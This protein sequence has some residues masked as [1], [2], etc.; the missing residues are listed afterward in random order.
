MDRS[1][2]IRGGI[3]G[4]RRIDGGFFFFLCALGWIVGVA[5]DG[6][7]RGGMYLKMLDGRMI[8]KDG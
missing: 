1:V 2:K 8:E 7:G 4:I 3:V 6:T 5:M